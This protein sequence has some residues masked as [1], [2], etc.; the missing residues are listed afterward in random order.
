MFISTLFT[1]I[2]CG[3]TSV[4]AKPELKSITAINNCGS[5]Y[6]VPVHPA[7]VLAPFKL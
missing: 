4:I 3:R 2:V 1:R 7:E 5:S 6:V